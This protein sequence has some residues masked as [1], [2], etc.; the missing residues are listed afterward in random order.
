[1]KKILAILLVLSAATVANG[2]AISQ[3]GGSIQGTITDPSG[4]SIP[5][6]AVTIS[7]PATGYTHD[8]KTDQAG[9]YTLGPLIPGPYVITVTATNFSKLTVKTVVEVG[10]VTSGNEKLQLGQSTE[11][12][13]V[14]AGEL[15]VNTEQAGVAGVV[16]QEQIATLPINGRNVLDI[17]QIQPGV[18]LQSG[19][20]FDPTKTGYSALSVNGANGRS[21]RVLIDGQDVSDETVGTVLF[22]IPEGAVDEFQLNR[23]TQDVSGSLTS[24]GQVLIATQSGT[25]RY[26][27]NMFYNFQDARAG[28]AH[29]GGIYG[30]FQRNQ[31]GGY[32]GGYIIKDKLFFFGGSERIKQANSS[33]V[34]SSLHFQTIYN[35]FPYVPDPF[36]DTFSVG[37]LDYNAPW[38]VH[39][40]ARATYSVNAG[41]GTSGQNPYALFINQDNIPALVGGADFT[42]G[43]FTHSVRF[44][45]I[46]FINALGNGSAALGN[47]V[48]NPGTVL[49]FPTEFIGGIYAGGNEDAPQKTFQS[50]KSFR[51]DGT[52]T[53][54]AHS[55][56]FGGEASRI[57]Q[58]GF[59]AFY[60]TF[61]TDISTSA[62]HVLATCASSTPIGPLV[63]T[64]C[65]DDPLY[66]Y[67][68]AEYVF[69]NG[70]GSGSER[71]G[72]GLPGG[73]DFSWRLAAY[74]G[75][76]WKVKPY[77]TIVA[78][79]RW[80]VDTDRAD[81]DL[82]TPTCG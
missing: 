33:P 51:Y 78:G 63:G 20:T 48:Y 44:G 28:F 36:K 10:T 22:N 18:I 41:F 68:P 2:Q 9:Y 16:T 13:E 59:A 38:G 76:N 17:A 73:A 30:P 66:G 11:T 40:F 53:K 32:V 52:W 64:T 72:F 69:G 67:K 39:L 46:K 26:H 4:A 74:V 45:Y 75:D 82:P 62:T 43:K 37:R 49:G 55:F 34:G 5:G 19:Q 42:T 80:S 61:L 47:T 56:K 54:G 58:G 57:L 60:G 14:N 65:P 70:N 77:L 3:N 12:I 27:G 23:S 50:S 29:V 15:Q 21:T 6:A 81:Q 35:Q 24:T 8:L 1:M 25:N 71:T 7:S 31:F 79:L